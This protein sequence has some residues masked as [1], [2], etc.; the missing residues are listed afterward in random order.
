Q[1]AHRDIHQS[2]L[3]YPAPGSPCAITAWPEMTSICLQ[4]TCPGSLI[5]RHIE[6]CR[7]CFHNKSPEGLQMGTFQHQ[8]SSEIQVRPRKMDFHFPDHLP[9]YWYNDNPYIT[10]FLNALSAVF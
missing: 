8:I 6:S 5:N 9:K 1:P 4:R 2:R 10:H 3:S 7:Q